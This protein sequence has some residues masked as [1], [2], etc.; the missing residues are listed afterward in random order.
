MSHTLSTA[1]SKT[2][3]VCRCIFSTYR[4]ISVSHVKDFLCILRKFTE[5]DRSSSESS[6]EY[7]ADSSTNSS[8]SLITLETNIE[9]AQLTSPGTEGYLTCVSMN[10]QTECLLWL[11]HLCVF[12]NFPFLVA[13]DISGLSREGDVFQGIL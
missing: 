8:N 1:A 11:F 3:L 2:R 10:F 7:R 5:F 13:L 6:A 12:P 4:P 9:T